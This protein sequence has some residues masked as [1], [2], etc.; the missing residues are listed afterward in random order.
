MLIDLLRDAAA[1]APDRP[2]VVTTERSLTYSDC[3]MRAEALA[4]GLLARSMSRAAVAVQEVGELLS[5]LCAASAIGVEVC[6]Y[7]DASDAAAVE[8]QACLLGHT[9]VLTDWELELS[10]DF[11]VIPL[12]DLA[13]GGALHKSVEQA[14]VLVLTTGTTGSPKAVRHD[15]ARLGSTLGRLDV[16]GPTR[17]LLAYNL[18]QFAGLQILL[19][20]LAMRATLV[21]PRSRQ[22]ADALAAMR[23]EKV[24]HVSATPTFWRMMTAHLKDD[25][26]VS[27]LH[28][29]QITLGGEAVP[30]SLLDE[31]KHLFPSTRVSQVYASTEFG[32]AVSVKDGRSGLPLSVLERGE[33]ADVQFRIVDGELHVRSRVG[34]VEALVDAWRPTG[35]LVEVCGDRIHFVGRSTDTINVGGVK[36]HPLPIEDVVGTVRGVKLARAYGRDNPITGEIVALEV[37]PRAGV[38]A[39][40]LKEAVRTA[41]EPLPPAA[42]PR[43]VRIVGD[44]SVSGDKITRRR[45]RS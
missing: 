43:H 45:A 25:D 11:E 32:S 16:G 17:W 41:C 33:E 23:A 26:S 4:R 9:V 15:W 8:E 37:V 2:V 44:L 20:A 13:V 7:R 42:Q 40:R 6:V 24:T 21:V 29:D 27:E 1:E 19:H 22:A 38:D 3:L 18:S 14:P 5:V 10:S 30:A 12:A 36:V 34:M 35:D 28:L 31:L 39:E